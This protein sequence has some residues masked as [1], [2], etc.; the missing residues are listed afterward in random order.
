MQDVLLAC[1]QEC[2]YFNQKRIPFF[3]FSHNHKKQTNMCAMKQTG[4]I[5]QLVG[6]RMQITAILNAIFISTP[7]FPANI[8]CNVIV[9]GSVLFSL[10]QIMEVHPSLVHPSIIRSPVCTVAVDAVCHASVCICSY[11]PFHTIE[12]TLTSTLFRME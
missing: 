3:F 12:A 2:R 11:S 5:P 10:I 8:C 6:L 1:C 7:I 9:F 4:V